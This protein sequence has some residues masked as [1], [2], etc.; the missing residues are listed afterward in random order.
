MKMGQ[1]VQENISYGTGGKMN[2][3]QRSSMVL[4]NGDNTFT[5]EL[6]DIYGYTYSESK[7][8]KIG[9]ESISN[10]SNQTPTL[11]MINPKSQDTN[12]NL[13]SGD[14]FNLRF[15]INVA[16]EAREV[17]VLIDNTIIQNASA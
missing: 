2:G 16:T 17:T 7:T 9:T 6:T 14:S 10:T 1:T 11:T 5:I 3:T 12:I 13:Y 15:N 8:L 4:K